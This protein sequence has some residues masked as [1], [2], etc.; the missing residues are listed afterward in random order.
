M[1]QLTRFAFVFCFAL[2]LLPISAAFAR[3][4]SS[5]QLGQSTL[6][7][8]LVNGAPHRFGVRLQSKA[9]T[10]E[11]AQ[12]LQIEIVGADDKSVWRSASYAQIERDGAQIVAR[13]ELK[14]AAGTRFVFTDNYAISAQAGGFT[15]ARDVQIFDAQIADIAFSTRY[16]L[17]S[18]AS[19]P[20]DGCDFFVPGVWYGHNDFVPPR[21]LAARLGDRD[22]FVREDRLPLPL[23]MLRQR[24]NGATL[25]LLHLD[26]DPQASRA[27]DGF[28]RVVDAQ[29]QFGSLGMMRRGPDEN[30]ALGA[31]FWFPGTE[32][33]RT[34]IGGGKAENGR[35][36]RRNHPVEVG[37]AHHYKLLAKLE[38]TPDF[39]AALQSSWRA[40]YAAYHPAIVPADLDKVYR[41]GFDLLDAVARPYEGEFSTNGTIALPF[42][43][44]MPDGNV[45]SRGAL[46]GQMGF[47][48]QQI[49]ACALLLRHGLE[50]GDAD[51]IK[52][53][54]TLIDFWA[55]QA[56][57][58]SGTL[59][60]W[61]DIGADGSRTWR[62]TK[63]FLRVTSDGVGG[64][65]QAWQ[66]AR[67]HGRE[68][69]NWLRFARAYGDWLVT[70]QNADGSYFRQYD[71]DSSPL[72]RSTDTTDHAIRF[73]VDLHK[74]TGAQSYR[75][76]AL[77]AGEFCLQNVDA[78]AA[79]VGGTPDNP[80]V[81]DKEGGVMALDA[82]LALTD[83]DGDKR[84]LGAATRA[85]T[86][87]ETW[88]YC[89]N[90]PCL[91]SDP[92][93]TFPA[94]RT[95]LGISLIAS[96]QSGADNFMAREVFGY[97]RLYLLTGDAHFRDFARFLLYDTKQLLDWDGS[98]GYKYPALQLEAMGLVGQRGHSVQ[99]WLP[100]LT[101][102]SIE[103]MARL[104]DVFGSFDIDE[105]DKRPLARLRAENAEYGATRGFEVR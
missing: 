26:G 60:T 22:Y 31:A 28:A 54:E 34:Y 64:A 7:F 6:E 62:D 55:D 49:P 90:I 104:K 65:L 71:F 38:Q 66:I 30:S 43:L 3:A 20:M 91:Q 76:A 50:S 9:A 93:N 87:C 80:N 47:V 15:V 70:H 96:G 53:A 19:L 69:P 40:A 99:T 57:T 59:R 37:V 27:D 94:N 52:R 58:P 29:M 102:A 100:W 11:R 25:T 61:F 56:A 97:Y 89:W 82:F 75:D 45:P 44:A 17:L 86:F 73:L 1:L 79:Y 88:T 46:S 83:L 24:A 23:S 2:A 105:L 35:Y 85:A 72:E 12:P 33:E 8:P 81:T 77:K 13:G 32:G 68:H 84:W 78:R 18:Q 16:E 74:A 42:L 51:A 63:M 67:A 48:G 95:T 21:A 36:A 92:K 5:L 10:F 101:V 4:E 41:D 14:S 39:P 103:P 98:L